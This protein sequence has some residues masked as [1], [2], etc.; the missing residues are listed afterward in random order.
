[1]IDRRQIRTSP[2][3]A[4]VALFE[5]DASAWRAPFVV[6]LALDVV[7]SMV[8]VNGA[9]LSIGC[10]SL[11][12][13]A[14]IAPELQVGVD[15]LVRPANVPGKLLNWLAKQHAERGFESIV[16]VAADII[17]LSPRLLSTALSVLATEDSVIGSTPGSLI[18]LLG[19]R[20]RILGSTSTELKSEIEVFTGCEVWPKVGRRVEWRPRLQELGSVEDFRTGANEHPK[21][22]PRTLHLLAHKPEQGEQ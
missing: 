22:L 5:P 10:E 16:F 2:R 20:A 15:L 14:L 19:V 13:A 21:F 11:E 8:A 12:A 6:P 1:M 4:V 18:Y 17:G 9:T 3:Q 7:G